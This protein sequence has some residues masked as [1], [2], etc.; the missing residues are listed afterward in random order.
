MGV[1]LIGVKNGL[2]EMTFKLKLD[3]QK[4]IGEKIG[5]KNVSV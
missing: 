1:I 3:L 5:E 2:F 4:G